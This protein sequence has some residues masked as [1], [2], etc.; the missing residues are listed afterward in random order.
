MPTSAALAFCEAGS[1]SQVRAFAGDVL[2]TE[3]M[4]ALHGY[5]VKEGEVELYL[6]R[7]E[8]RTVVETLRRGQ[9]FGFEPHLGKPVRLQ[10]AAARGYCELYVV[11]NGAATQ[12]LGAA[13][14]LLRGLVVSAS[15]RLA[16]AHELIARRVSF[17]PELMAYAQMLQL[18]G[19][20][21][22]KPRPEGPGPELAR[23]PLQA[24]VNHAQA[25]F[26]HSDR[27]IRALLRKLVNLHLI[28]I[29]DERG[30][31]K[32]VVY[33]P[34]DIVGQA[35][36]SAIDDAEADRQTHQYLSLDEFAALVD[37][38]RGVLL[39]KL[40]GDEF[41]EDVFTFR[42]E[43]ILRVLDRKGRKF[44]ATRK[45]K[46]PAEF[47]DLDDLAFADTRA[48]FDAVA[49]MDSFD[50]AKLLHGLAEGEARQRILGALSSRRRSDVES[51]LAGLQVV[52]PVEAQRLGSALVQQVRDAMMK[53]AA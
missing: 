2:Y 13:S 45:L 15:K 44:F 4:P 28:R 49:R 1:F 51:D 31:G 32:Q 50:I 16:A 53:Q 26:G 18:I 14:D 17:Q 42:R 39:K 41:A 36:K 29:E 10:C 24:V 40:A 5:V 11:D 6:V 48:V 12:A 25:L 8:K 20:P 33:A 37:V 22:L 34:R 30:S 38:D 3:G 23:P 35:R 27:H 21:E 47:A 7:D 43:E 9:V 19:M 52:D 46:S